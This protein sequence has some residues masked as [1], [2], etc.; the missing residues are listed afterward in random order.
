MDVRVRKHCSPTSPQDVE[1]VKQAGGTAGEE[2]RWAAVV[3]GRRADSRLIEAGLPG[4]VLLWVLPLVGGIPVGGSSCLLLLGLG[5]CLS[6]CPGFGVE[7]SLRF[8]L[9]RWADRG[10]GVLAGLLGCAIGAGTCSPSQLGFRDQTGSFPHAFL[11]VV[12][13]Q[14]VTFVALFSLVV[15]AKD[16]GQVGVLRP[17]R[18]GQRVEVQFGAFLQEL[19]DGQRGLFDHQ[20]GLIGESRIHKV[21]LTLF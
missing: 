16:G 4:P 19:I 1:L 15:V 13:H 10:L 21:A 11:T 18:G 8:S 2:G 12:L 17:H 20:P 5:L 14:T 3:P 9:L 7:E 6:W